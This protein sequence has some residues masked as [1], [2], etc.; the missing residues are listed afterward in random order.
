MLPGTSGLAGGGIY[1]AE[2]AA[3]T[4]H[5]AFNL[6]VVLEADVRLG[7]TKTVAPW[8]ED[9]TY[10][11]LLRQGYDSVL[12]PR[13]NGYELVVYN[14]DQVVNVRVH[15]VRKQHVHRHTYNRAG[16]FAGYQPTGYMN[17]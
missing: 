6:G 10:D 7:C 2:T 4:D 5:K 11:S 17:A 15:A 1:F 16:H 13:Q 8:G 12:I 14:P 9:V 3:H